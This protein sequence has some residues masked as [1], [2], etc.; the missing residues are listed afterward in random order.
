MPGYDQ[1][2]IAHLEERLAVGP[3]TTGRSA[4]SELEMLADLYLEADSYMP[5]LE[6]IERLLSLPDARTLSRSR[7]AAIGSK[8][9]ACRIAQGDCQGALAQ[10]RELLRVESDL[11]HLPVRCKLH[12]QSAEALFRL[13]RLEDCVAS[14]ERALSLADQSADLALSAQALNLLGRAE[15]RKGDLVRARD[16]YEQALGLFRRVG[17]ETG[18]AHIRNNLGLVHKNLCEWEVA[19]SHLREAAEVHRKAGHYAECANPLMNLGIVCQKS[20]DWRQAA[21]CYSEAHKIYLQVGDQLRLSVVTIGLGNIARLER[22]FDE[23]ERLLAE[24]RVR[25]REQGARREEVLAIEFMG[26]L[27]HDRGRYD[28]ALAGYDEALKLAEP[29]APEGDLVVELER[30][31]ADALCALGRLDDAARACDRAER[32]AARTQDRLEQ[33]ITIRVA[34]SIA[35]KRGDRAAAFESWQRSTSRLEECRESFELGRTF[36]EM[37]RAT[38][39][40]TRARRYFYRAI[41]AFGSLPISYWLEQADHELLR[42][43]FTAPEATPPSRP[44]SLLGRR[45]RAPSLVACSND[46][47]RVETLA[48]RAASTELSVLITGETGTGKELVARTIHSLSARAHRPF[49]AV[50]CGALRAD[51]ALSQLF[52]HRKGAFTGAHA[53]GIGLVEAAHGG[54]LFLDEVGELPSDVQVTLLRFLESGEYLRL[55]ETQVRRADVRVIAATNRELRDIEGEKLF[56]RDLLFRLNEIEIRLPTLRERGEDIIPLARHFLAFYGGMEGPRLGADAESVLRSY[57]WPGNVRELENVMKRLAALHSGDGEVDAVALLP[58]LDHPPLMRSAE[59]RNGHAST[60]DRAAILAAYSEAGG[61]KSRVAD[62]LGV[63]RKTLYARLKRLHL[64][65]P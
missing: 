36:L 43:Q 22:R 20:G 24:A 64:E 11:E 39:D 62:I 15:Y 40:A 61:N 48:Q 27:N 32:L 21:E 12:L 55:G 56:R 28:E 49:L 34:G 41:A 26:E 58:F 10:C 9:I 4:V 52:G 37:G 13:G 45:L 33:A 25:A 50:N 30:R 3:L 51:L 5:A 14:A 31:R 57:A 23:A 6:T 63:S 54:T 2:R 35:W 1:D 44:A 47:R 18:A 8:A 19:A 16:L 38:E 42:L 59:P 17:D 29:I 60:D 65:L 7:R 46:M 53:E